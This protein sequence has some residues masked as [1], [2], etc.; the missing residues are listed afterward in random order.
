MLGGFLGWI[1]GHAL[2]A[3][4]SPLIESRTGVSIGFWDFAPGVPILSFLGISGPSSSAG[5]DLE[6]LRVSTELFLI[7]GLILLA[8]M[9]GVYPA[10]SAY[11]TDVAESL[12]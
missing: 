11:R 6:W 1:A 7:P 12:D 4:A 9:V 5:A 10:I 8:V 2:N 3:A